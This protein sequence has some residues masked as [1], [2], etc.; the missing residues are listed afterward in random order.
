MGA[1]M[2]LIAQLEL[3]YGGVAEFMAV[4]PKVRA[5]MEQRGCKMIHAFSQETGRLNTFVHIWQLD[6]ANSYVDAV[7]DLRQSPE[8]G[9]IVASLAKSVVNETLTLASALPYGP[10]A[11]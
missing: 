6:S 2:Y 5:A 8:I 9:D 11:A 7:A 3:S 10:D 1:P 4:A